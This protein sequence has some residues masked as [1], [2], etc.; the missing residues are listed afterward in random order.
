MSDL[1]LEQFP[2]QIGDLVGEL[3][4][5]G[6]VDL[7]CLSVRPSQIEE[8]DEPETGE[9]GPADQVEKILEPFAQVSATD[10]T[11][12]S[13][14]GLAIAERHVRLHGGRVWVQDAPGGGAEF[15]V[16]L[17]VREKR[18]ARR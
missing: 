6:P 13:G 18:T 12:G 2:A 16:E 11:R 5:V 3:F 4:A 10:A 7:G 8:P 15:T 17:P 14:L 9:A 1:Q